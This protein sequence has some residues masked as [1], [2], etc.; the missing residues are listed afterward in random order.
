[1]RDT[2]KSPK[3]VAKTVTTAKPRKVIKPR[4]RLTGT[5]S[6]AIRAI[7]ERTRVGRAEIDGVINA[8]P[9]TSDACDR[10]PRRNNTRPT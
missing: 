9:P 8:R 10:D 7:L 5:L 4:A 6:P 2:R 3:K 1:M